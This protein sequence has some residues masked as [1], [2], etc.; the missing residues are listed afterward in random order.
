L[1][2]T[3]AGFPGGNCWAWTDIGLKTTFHTSIVGNIKFKGYFGYKFTAFEISIPG[4]PVVGIANGYVKAKKYIYNSNDDIVTE[5]EFEDID[6]ET[7]FDF[8]ILSF[9][10][11]EKNWPYST[12]VSSYGFTAG[13]TYYLGV[14]VDSW[15]EAAGV[16]RDTALA[17]WNLEEIVFID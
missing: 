16:A 1:V 7:Y 15:S 8:A 12:S 14:F 6:A 17:D 5:I 3:D 9:G 2:K 4:F 11:G 10:Y 13:K